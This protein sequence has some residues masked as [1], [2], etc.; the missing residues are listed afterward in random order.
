MKPREYKKTVEFP[1]TD[2]IIYNFEYQVTDRESKFIRFTFA[3]HSYQ[4]EALLK[5]AGYTKKGEN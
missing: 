2:R 1:A 4:F 3:E 5:E